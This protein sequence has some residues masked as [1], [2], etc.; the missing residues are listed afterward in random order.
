[1]SASRAPAPGPS[2]CPRALPTTTGA[3]EK[4]TQQSCGS[5]PQRRSIRFAIASMPNPCGSCFPH[6]S[7]QPEC[8][9]SSAQASSERK[10]APRT[11]SAAPAGESRPSEQSRRTRWN[12]LRYGRWQTGGNASPR[13]SLSSPSTVPGSLA[14]DVRQTARSGGMCP[15]SSSSAVGRNDGRQVGNPAESASRARRPRGTVRRKPSRPVSPQAVRLREDAEAFFRRAGRHHEHALA[16]STSVA[17]GGASRNDATAAVQ[18]SACWRLQF[19]WSA[20]Q[21]APRVM[22]SLE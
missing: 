6:A 21:R 8:Q 13:P 22:L 18:R 15:A 19:A 11:R 7:E 17:G 4:R 14:K 20:S 3:S 2:A 10:R 5:L 9:R 1:M 16:E 12:C